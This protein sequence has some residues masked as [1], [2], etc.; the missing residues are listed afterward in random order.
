[1]CFRGKLHGHDVQDQDALG[2]DILVDGAGLVHYEYVLVS[3]NFRG[4]QVIRY[5]DGHDAW[6]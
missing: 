1:M 4:W 3:E 2:T 5:I 6:V